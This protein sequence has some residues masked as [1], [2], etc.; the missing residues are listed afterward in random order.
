MS[1]PMR[2]A[3]D[4]MGGDYAPHLIVEGS[5]QAARRLGHEI[6]LVGDPAVLEQHLAASGDRPAN[7]RIEPSDSLVGM[8]ESPAQACRQKP[9]SSIMVAARLVGQGQADAVDSA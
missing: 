1:N 8:D 6:I 7:V 2:I 9:N 3:V 4:A 5:L